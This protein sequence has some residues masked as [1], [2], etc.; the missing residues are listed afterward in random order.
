MDPVQLDALIHRIDQELLPELDLESVEPHN[1]VVAHRVPQPWQ[2]LGTGNYAAVLCHPTF[3][4]QVVKV[5]APGRPGLP[6]EQEVYRRLGSHPGF[7]ECFA[8]GDNFLVL[9]RLYGTTLYDC[10]HQGKLI[11]KRV[12]QDID[13]ALAYARSRGLHP[14]DVHGRNVMMWNDRGIV[15]DV[16][17]FLQDEACSAWDDL[18]TAYYWIYRPLIAP[19]RLRS[20]Y[21]LLDWVRASYRG[22]RR[23]FRRGR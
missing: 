9:K 22:F 21:V 1:P 6:D 7:S 5:Y 17:D 13:L 19:L 16:S 15:A 12:I 14:H 10:L 23:L 18:K 20:P 4:D 2:L 3:P 8:A 11:P